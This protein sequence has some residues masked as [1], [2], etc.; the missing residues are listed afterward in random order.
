MSSSSLHAIRL[1]FGGGI[2]QK[3]NY[4]M[5]NVLCCKYNYKS[6]YR[7]STCSTTTRVRTTVRSHIHRRPV[8]TLAQVRGF[9]FECKRWEHLPENA[10]ILGL[11]VNTKS[12]GFCVSDRR[13]SVI[14]CGTIDTSKTGSILA[15]A[16]VM[17][18]ILSTDIKPSMESD[19]QVHWIVGVE[20]YLR[21]TGWGRTNNHTLFALAEVNALARYV[22]EQVFQVS[23]TVVHPAI[24]RKLFGIEAPKKLIKNAVFEYV[25]TNVLPDYEWPKT[26][27]GRL[28][29]ESYD[30][31]DAALITLATIK[32]HSDQV[33]IE[34][35]QVRKEFT[36]QLHLYARSKANPG[37]LLNLEGEELTKLM[38][39]VITERVPP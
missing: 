5:A 7:T 8:V 3:L 21:T 23:A 17:R 37:V 36:R 27:T 29:D 1:K 26:R 25:S 20:D 13:G 32:L 14:R 24:P 34:D 19:Q 11:D 12:T 2:A 39:R 28:R 33:L 30:V 35:E 9:E 10:R 16:H 4:R 31:A 18:N 38:S 22:C 6:T 15:S